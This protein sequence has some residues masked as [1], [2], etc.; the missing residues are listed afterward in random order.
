MKPKIISCLVYILL[1]AYCVQAAGPDTSDR[2]QAP[3]RVVITQ[4]P[5][6]INRIKDPV[7]EIRYRRA[8]FM[9][10]L[11]GRFGNGSLQHVQTVFIFNRANSCDSLTLI[12][13]VQAADLLS[14][15]FRFKMPTLFTF[16]DSV[17]MVIT[18]RLKS[19]ITLSQT[20]SA[21]FTRV[22]FAEIDQ[23]YVLSESESP[24]CRLP[25]GKVVR[26]PGE[27]GVH[28]YRI[29]GIARTN[30]GRL[31]AVYDVRHESVWD[32]P[33]KI[34]IGMSFSDDEGITWSSM[35]IIMHKENEENILNGIGD[36]SILVDKQTNNIWVA[37]LWSRGNH[38]FLSSGPGLAPD[39]T[40]QFV[41]ARSRDNGDS[42]DPIINIT[43]SVKVPEWR[44]LFQGPGSGISCKDGTL[45]F[46]AQFKNAAGIPYSTILYSKDKGA[47]WQVGAGASPGTTES[48]V[49]ELSDGRLLLN[50]RDNK[51]DFRTLAVTGDLGKSWS[52]YRTPS[53][54]LTD[55]ICMGSMISFRYMGK[56][57]LAFSNPNTQKGRYNLTIRFS[58]NDGKT[59][60]A[61]HNIP[62]DNRYFYGYSSLVY[63]GDH[64][65]GVLY[66]GKR[67]ILF[68]SFELPRGI[69]AAIS[70]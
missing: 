20:I 56:Q 54:N 12:D 50:M 9:D 38:G 29:P 58:L 5:V 13:S 55:P 45:V 60:P 52:G 31:I 35:K 26:D 41:L 68:T 69:P 24:F 25:V 63:L 64:R 3:C 53:N 27:D 11:Y 66:E 10:S 2:L 57:V 42:W 4:H 39:Q 62:V 46:P 51:G 67:D 49:A 61:E 28:T 33:G 59:W 23:P 36:P 43:S 18:V 15:V 22:K 65:I 37:A 7:L 6:F 70:Q 16:E 17:A 21:R 1:T 30:T 44:I 8:D 19:N 40:G 48:A 32:L 47:S 34:D 14:G